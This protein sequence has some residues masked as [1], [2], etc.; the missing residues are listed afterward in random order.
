MK[1]SSLNCVVSM[2]EQCLA[3]TSM[4]VLGD[5]KNYH[6]LP[7]YIL[8]RAT[9]NGRQMIAGNWG[10]VRSNDPDFVWEITPTPNRFWGM[11]D[12]ELDQ[13]PDH[14]QDYL[15]EWEISASAFG[16]QMMNFFITRREMNF[17]KPIEFL[18]K[19]CA[20]KGWKSSE[21]SLE[22]WLFHYLGVYIEN[23]V[24]EDSSKIKAKE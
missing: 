8:V 13:L 11:S 18:H 24:V 12:E 2:C 23:A 15:T 20:K 22:T 6:V 17:F 19:A 1:H 3:E 16:K 7:G 21:A 14:E 10:L 5:N 9:K 4:Y